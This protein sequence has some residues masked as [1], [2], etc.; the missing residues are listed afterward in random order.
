MT[1][2]VAATRPSRAVPAGVAAL[3]LAGVTLLSGCQE[4]ESAATESGYQPSEVEE[5]DGGD[6]VQV[7]FTRDAAS[8]VGLQRAAAVTVDGQTVV[9]YAALIYDGQGVPWVYTAPDELTFRRVQVDV[10]RIEGDRVFLSGGLAAGTQVVTVGATEVY[11]TEMGIS[12]GK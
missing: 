6:A 2:G 8:R 10:D 3:V 1:A 5:V 4:V 11:G 12:G 9:S 7:T